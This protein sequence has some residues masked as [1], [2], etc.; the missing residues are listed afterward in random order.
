M[1]LNTGDVF[2]GYT[3]QRLLGTGGMGEVYLAQHPRLP[4]QDALK[5]LPE[6]LTSDT[7]YRQRFN[8]EADIA[9]GLWHPH[10]V[11]LHDRGE[12]DGQLWIA[13]DYVD[14]TDA[15]RLV[16]EHH[17]RGMPLRE[18]I[19]IVTAIAEALDYAHARNLLH[20]DVKPSNIL[21]T[22][23]D[24]AT[25]AQRRILLADFGVARRTDDISGLTA[26]NMAVGSMAYAAPE[27]LLGQATDG[28]ADQYALAASA[29]HLL[30][31]RSPFHHSNPAVV[32]SKHLN[33]SP[34]R[35]S[36][37]RPELA[38]L[39]AVLSKGLAKEPDARYPR[40]E[41]LARAF[42]AVATVAAKPVERVRPP[43]PPPPPPRPM[44]MPPTVAPPG[45]SPSISVPPAAAWSS[46]PPTLQPRPAQ[47]RRPTTVLIPAVLAVLLVFAIG[48]AVT[49]FGRSAPAAST[50]PQWQPYVEAARDFGLNY[51]TVSADSVDAD[52]PS[53]LDGSTGPLHDELQKDAA[54][55]KQKAVAD[56]TKADG[57]VTGAGIESFSSDEA[58]VLVSIDTRTT[59]NTN[60]PR[61]DAVQRLAVTVVSVGDGYKASKLEFVD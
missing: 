10:I 4:R 23:P 5:I 54:Q 31:G 53:L 18:T 32:I 43:D 21:L 20:R 37:S 6:S 40:C 52:I 22:Q 26:T 47:K 44:V 17:P 29:F 15:S 3:I 59:E 35:L 36:E 56:G 46:T 39:D 60:A 9:A 11:G 28:R 1:P 8:R 24:H 42:A 25:R 2:A 14:G 41:D 48:F 55:L 58:V 16:R 50:T 57:T 33:E 38:H 51:V 34:P 45:S 7:Q 13:M 27:Q 61:Q 19:E 12:T 30:T 49:Q